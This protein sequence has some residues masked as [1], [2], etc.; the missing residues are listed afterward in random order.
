MNFGINKSM[1]YD[2]LKSDY[3]WIDGL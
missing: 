2:S 3:S 1:I